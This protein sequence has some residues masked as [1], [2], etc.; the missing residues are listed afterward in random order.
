MTFHSLSN[1]MADT[2]YRKGTLAGLA[3]PYSKKNKLP[4]VAQHHSEEGA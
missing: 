2:W 1:K 4:L 3:L